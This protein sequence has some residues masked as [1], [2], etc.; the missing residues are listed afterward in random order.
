M[1]YKYTIRVNDAV[2]YTNSLD[3]R[4]PFVWSDEEK[5]LY[6]ITEER[7]CLLPDA[8]LDGVHGNYEMI[9]MA[10]F[11]Q[12]SAEEAY[13]ILKDTIGDAFDD[14]KGQEL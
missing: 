9:R 2:L 5:I 10:C 13:K 6:R 4:Y 3:I 7:E 12:T 8:Y 11:P 1:D 14:T